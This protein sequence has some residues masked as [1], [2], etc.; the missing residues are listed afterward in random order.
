M[1]GGFEKPQQM[2]TYNSPKKKQKLI[3]ESNRLMIKKL[4]LSLNFQGG[5]R[6]CQGIVCIWGNTFHVF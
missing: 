3:I 6:W 2:P 1:L 5:K 4:L